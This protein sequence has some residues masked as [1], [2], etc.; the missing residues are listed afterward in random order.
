MPIG[1][2]LLPVNLQSHDRLRHKSLGSVQA[3]DNRGNPV[4]QKRPPFGSER[5]DDLNA[6]SSHTGAKPISV[7]MDELR[8][9]EILADHFA[10]D[11]STV[12][13][14]QRLQGIKSPRPFTVVPTEPLG[15]AAHLASRWLS[16][17]ERCC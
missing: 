15:G 3:V 11:K 13:G 12:D 1:G 6:S 2:T 10:L 5:T 17:D 14:R 4:S 8:G 16:G 7:D 9:P